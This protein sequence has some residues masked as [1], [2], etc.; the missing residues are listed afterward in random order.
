M[1]VFLL[2]LLIVAM[3]CDQNVGE[4]INIGPTPAESVAASSPTL[5]IQDTVRQ[6]NATPLFTSRPIAQPPTLT[7][8]TTASGAINGPTPTLTDPHHHVVDVV[9]ST[10][11]P[12]IAEKFA[13]L[14]VVLDSQVERYKVTANAEGTYQAFC[15]EELLPSGSFR[16]RLVVED[17]GSGKTYEIAGLSPRPRDFSSLVWLGQV[18]VFDK[19]SQP[20]YGL[21]YAVDVQNGTLLLAAPFPDRLP[22]PGTP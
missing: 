9:A 12:E 16:E 10:V 3:G 14:E 15:I 22:S 13:F 11:P 1:I 7:A 18:L 6:T 21:H 19:W 20:H 2:S 5:V 4:G 17:L 8:P